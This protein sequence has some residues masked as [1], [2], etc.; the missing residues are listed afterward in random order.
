MALTIGHPPPLSQTLQQM[1]ELAAKGR[2]NVRWQLRLPD[3]FMPLPA[4]AS[5]KT[6]AAVH[7]RELMTRLLTQRSNTAWLSLCAHLQDSVHLTTFLAR[8]EEPAALTVIVTPR[9]K[10]ASVYLPVAPP[11]SSLAEALAKQPT[12]VSYEI[13]WDV[14]AD[15]GGKAQAHGSILQKP[16]G[17][18]S[19]NTFATPDDVLTTQVLQTGDGPD[20]LIERWLELEPAP[21]RKP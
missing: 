14:S 6:P 1:V 7:Q 19:A 15:V 4:N 17:H 11:D 8:D 5:E 9:V 21:R 10:V 18:L 20:V 16:A 12:P 2:G 13:S 3:D